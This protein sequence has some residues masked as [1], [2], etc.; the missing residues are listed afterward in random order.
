MKCIYSFILF[1]FL[2]SQ[3]STISLT[4]FGEYV[5]T[6]DASSVGIGDSKYFNGYSDRINFSSC[7]SYWKSSFSNLMMSIDVHNYSLE[8][9]N[10]VSNNF[11]MLSFSF[12]LRVCRSGSA[13]FDDDDWGQR[14]LGLQ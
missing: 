9:D 14:G 12:F 8:S 6:Y 2:F 1:A 3:T 4:G 13:M 10:L 11:K 7:S 5:N